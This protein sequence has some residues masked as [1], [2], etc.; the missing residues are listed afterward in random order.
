MDIAAWYAARPMDELRAR[1][2]DV[3]ATS[4]RRTVDQLAL[5]TSPA[6]LGLTSIDMVEIVFELEEALGIS[7]PYD[8]PRAGERP[9][10]ELVDR[11]EQ[12]ARERGP[13]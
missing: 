2:L 13:T 6:D 3:M 8:D 7:V 10:G 9:L 4:T 5:D 1:I 11:I 12:L